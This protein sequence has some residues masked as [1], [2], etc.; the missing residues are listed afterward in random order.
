M[1]IPLFSLDNQKAYVELGYYC[2]TLCGYGEAIYLKKINGKWT[3][4]EKWKL[5]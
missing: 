1:T 4:V 3:I 2:G 5:G